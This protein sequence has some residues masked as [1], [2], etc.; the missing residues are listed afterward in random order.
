MGLMQVMPETYDGSAGRAT[1]SATTPMTRT[2][3]FWPG[4]AYIREMYDRFG[5]PGFL[6]AYNAGPDRVDSYLAGAADLPDE[7]VNYLA[8]ITPNL[9]NAVPL[10]G[11]LAMYASA[12]TG[13]GARA[14][15]ASP[16]WRP[17]AT[18]T[19]PTTRTIPAP[20]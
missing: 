19:P 20:R 17:V 9:G 6:A 4:T 8:A 5:A 1:G 10:S 12:R 16:A 14:L 3:T 2:T 13:R 7:T 18:S 15:R 11:P